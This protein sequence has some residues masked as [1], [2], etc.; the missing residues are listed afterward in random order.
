MATYALSDHRTQ[1]FLLQK[2]G[3][4]LHMERAVA[5]MRKRVKEFYDGTSAYF[6]HQGE[7][8]MAKRRARLMKDFSND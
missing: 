7:K 5:L 8:E 2:Y 1:E 4:T 6:P 3:A